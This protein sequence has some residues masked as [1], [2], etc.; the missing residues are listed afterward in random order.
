[1]N[2]HN[3]HFNLICHFNG[4]SLYSYLPLGEV[5]AKPILASVDDVRVRKFPSSLHCR[6]HPAN[7]VK[8]TFNRIFEVQD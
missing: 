4:I 7:Y 1:M 6:W 5:M 8:L 2:N 3:F